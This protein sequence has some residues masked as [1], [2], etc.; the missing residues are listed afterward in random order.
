MNPTSITQDQFL[1]SLRY[2]IV[3]AG[4]YATGRGYISSE[5]LGNIVTI[6]A[7]LGPLAWGLYVNW[8]KSQQTKIATAAGVQAGI[9]LTVASSALDVNNNPIRVGGGFPAKPVTLATAP[10]IV[11]NFGPAAPPPAA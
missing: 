11:K 1:T 2:L 9:N 8:Q 10:D 4:A 3:W 6:S 7:V 5:T